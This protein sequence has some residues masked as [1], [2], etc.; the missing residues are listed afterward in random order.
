MSL[1]LNQKLRGIFEARQATLVPGAFNALSARIVADLG[2][3]AIYVTGAG[4]TNGSLGMPGLGLITL[5]NIADHVM[6]MNQVVDV[7]L[8]VDADTGFGNAINTYHTI[9]VLERAGAS[10]VQLEDQQ[11]PKRC[12]HFAGK[13]VIPTNEMVAKVKAAADARHTDMMI[14]AR[15]DA[16]ATKGLDD[17]I[18]RANRY[19]EAGADAV[20]IEAPKSAE[21]I[22]EMTRQVK[23]PHMVNMVIGGQTPILDREELQSYGVSVVLYANVALQS[24]I[25]GMQKALVQLKETGAVPEEAGITATFKERQRLVGKPEFDRLE[26]LYTV[27]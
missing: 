27:A 23:A 13:D 10:G 22:R 3:P 2:Y 19:V 25:L 9:R 26:K 16:R 12:G 18:D 5:T 20:F 15:T 4:V 8:I 24:A 1:T 11:F 6:A 21:E 14:I 17:A 7:A